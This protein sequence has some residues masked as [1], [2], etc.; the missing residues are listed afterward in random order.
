MK[1][2]VAI[3]L[4]LALA[5]LVRRKLLR[6]DHSFPLFGA[7]VV[8]GFAAVSDRFIDSVAAGLGI[9]YAP[10]AIILIAIF[11]VLALVT[12]IVV[13]ISRL[14][15]NQISFIRRLAEIELN[16]QESERSNRH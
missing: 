1:L 12:I 5:T 16:V 3:I 4:F 9:I 15:E 10:L 11:I 8:L 7:I 14:R 2:L 6:I 13:V